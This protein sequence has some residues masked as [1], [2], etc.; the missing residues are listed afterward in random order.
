MQI[1]AGEDMTPISYSEWAAGAAGSPRAIF[2]GDNLKVL[3]KLHGVYDNRVSC[4]YID[5]PYNNGE[6][7]AYYEDDASHEQWLAQMKAILSELKPFLKKNGSI[8]ISID[9][10]EMHYLK[11][12]CDAVFG[13]KSFVTTIVWQQRNTRENR[14]AF[15]NNHEYILVYSPDPA[16]F[17]KKRHL[18]PLTNEVLARYSN[19]DND[20]RGP[21][22]S[23][24]A[25]VQ[26]GHAVASQF[27]EIVAPNGKRHKPPQGRCWIYNQERMRREIEAGNIWFGSD[28]NGVPRVKKFISGRMNGI[29]PE[30]LW[31]S[32]F[33]GTNKDAKTHLQKLKLYDKNLFDTPKPE[34]LIGQIIEIAT[35]E[36]EIVLDA[37]LGS[38]TTAAAAHKL[39]RGYIGIER[40]ALTCGYAAKRLEQV[41][42]GEQGGLSKR[43]G[44]R[45]GGS[46]SFIDFT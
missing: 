20:P 41:I 24:T 43:I 18:L 9:D 37:F 3:G 27:Y 34:T 36:G 1:G 30:T 10:G 35:D 16:A 26:D 19:L 2:K 39:G 12:L 6:R 29:V 31:L 14:K 38:G 11:V 33:V 45:G 23:V 13:R 15:S 4:I 40:E 22:Q 17:K 25:N 21:W 7:Y 42:A 44:W 8:W 28:G 46:Y 32:S 5:P